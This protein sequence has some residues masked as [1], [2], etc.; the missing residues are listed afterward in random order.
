MSD[1]PTRT[2]TAAGTASAGPSDLAAVRV[3]G[4]L[5]DAQLLRLPDQPKRGAWQAGTQPI[6]GEMWPAPRELGCRGT[7]GITD[8]LDTKGLAVMHR[9]ERPE[10]TR[11]F[12]T[13]A[14]NGP[15]TW[16]DATPHTHPHGP[17]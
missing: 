7:P 11:D 6:G 10:D 17:S 13:P 4:A 1:Q 9:S 14:L 12:Y 5:G 15:V 3:G 8:D 2:G 16:G